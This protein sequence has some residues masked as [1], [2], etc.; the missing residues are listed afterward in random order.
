MSDR[1]Y[2]AS[3]ATKLWGLGKTTIRSAI[4]S[5]RFKRGEVRKSGK[6]WLVKESAMKRL[7]GDPKIKVSDQ[8]ADTACYE[9]GDGWYLKMGD[10]WVCQYCG[11]TID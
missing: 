6:V 1:I 11:H 4:R 7:Y 5:G 8:I 10:S 3:E 2:T 9:C